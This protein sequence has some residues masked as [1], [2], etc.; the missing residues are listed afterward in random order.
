MDLPARDVIL[1]RHAM[2]LF[3]ARRIL[4][5]KQAEL[6][7]AKKNHDL[8][9]KAWEQACYAAEGG[10][11]DTDYPGGDPRLPDEEVSTR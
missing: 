8:C 11:S 1:L 10:R 6:D 3:E 4:N 5:D 2:R 9:L 7:E